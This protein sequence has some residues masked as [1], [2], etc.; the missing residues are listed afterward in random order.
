[1]L[2]FDTLFAEEAEEVDGGASF[3]ALFPGFGLLT[4]S[5]LGLSEVTSG[6]GI[7][8]LLQLPAAVMLLL[9]VLLMLDKDAVL[10][11]GTSERELGVCALSFSS[12]S[13]V[14][15]AMLRILL[16][17]LLLRTSF[18]FDFSIV[19]VIFD[20]DFFSAI[21]ETFLVETAILPAEKDDD[22]EDEVE[23]RDEKETEDGI[24][25]EQFSSDV[26]LISLRFRPGFDGSFILVL[27]WE[28]VVGAVE[29]PPVGRDWG[30]VADEGAWRR[31][32]IGEW[33]VSISCLRNLSAAAAV[34]LSENTRRSEDEEDEE[35][36]QLFG[37]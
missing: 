23:G 4:L 17:L 2:S 15:L 25:S 30:F 19:V 6:V 11:G 20:V 18:V 13:S 9:A 14:G 32:S 37:S 28:G 1:M 26:V 27:A 7:G 22:E 12:Q 21:L 34:S 29:S 10:L 31:D 8:D 33:Q 24:T 5:R 3:E 16:L 35:E 36:E